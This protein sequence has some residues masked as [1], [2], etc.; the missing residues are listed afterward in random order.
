MQTLELNK[1]GLQCLSFEEVL[2]IDGGRVS[3][4]TLKKIWDGAK[5]VVEKAGIVDF[6]CDLWDGMKE[7]YHE[8]RH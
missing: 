6:F 2:E 3:G 8:A 7:G 1:M 5:W 4:K